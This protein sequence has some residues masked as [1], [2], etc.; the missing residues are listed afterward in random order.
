MPIAK[1]RN[2]PMNHW[3]LRKK[4][5]PKIV[6]LENALPARFPDE[7]EMWTPYVDNGININNART[8]PSRTRDSSSKCRKYRN[9][10]EYSQHNEDK[11]DLTRRLW[12]LPSIGNNFLPFRKCNSRKST[13]AHE[14]IAR[15]RPKFNRCI[16]RQ[17]HENTL[18]LPLIETSERVKSN[19]YDPT[20]LHEKLYVFRR[21]KGT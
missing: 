4:V 16:S 5:M 3:R 15:Y 17:V 2:I 21:Y 10:F 13:D 6:Q 1:S 19:V 18:I 9:L 14:D 11:L 7:L 20:N 12:K 8:L